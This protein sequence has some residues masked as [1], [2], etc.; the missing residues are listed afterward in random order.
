MPYAIVQ[1]AQPAL[2]FLP[3]DY[4][5]WLHRL[6]KT[7]LPFLLRSHGIQRVET[8]G[9]E[10]LA[11][12][13]AQF[14]ARQARV[15]LAFRHPSTQDPLVLAHL[16][17]KTVPTVARRNRIPLRSPVHSQ[18]LYDR[19][20][21]IWAG[22]F[23]GWV[24]SKMGGIPI[25]RGKLDRLALKT[26]RAG[27]INSEFPLAIAPEGATNNHSEILS[28]LEPGIAQLA[29]WC[30]EDLATAQRS[31]SVFIIPISLQYPFVDRQ[32][33]ASIDHLLTDC[34]QQ[35]RLVQKRSPAVE[36]SDEQRYTR[37]ARLGLEMLT[38]IEAFYRQA[39]GQILEDKHTQTTTQETPNLDF[40]LRLQHLREV[41]L[42]VAE[43]H[44]NLPA[45]GTI[46]DR[47]RR[48]EQAGWDRIYRENLDQLSPVARGLADWNAI[49]AS[50][51]MGHM[52]LVEQFAAVSGSYVREKPT[53]D[54]YAEVL[55]IIARAI[56]WIEGRNPQSI[57]QLGKKIAKIQIGE[58]INVSDRYQNYRQNRRTA[59]G[60]LTA[61]LQIQLEQ[62]ILK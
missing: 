44:F 3:P 60:Q 51:R 7:V 39:Y 15:I 53:I 34:E 38:L 50:I 45:K 37:F 36:H 12:L 2:R 14:Q 18:F 17:W 27:L 46:S 41:A 9:S 29:F 59:I 52:R 13:L 32:N 20:I 16:L 1:Q 6:V 43:S 42:T 31:E 25:Q 33:W 21:P 55:T 56:A 26:A 22:Q 35:L 57:P 40:T 28:P 61:D 24:L 11:R 19:G 4:Q 62:S 58:P 49:E 48:I 5:P 30:C 23:T 10:E 54:R 8:T 47:C